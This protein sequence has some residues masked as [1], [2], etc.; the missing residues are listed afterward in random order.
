M[1]PTITTPAMT[2][3]VGVILGTAAY[4][5]PEQAQGQAGRQAQRHL[6]VR[7]RAVRDADRAA[8]LRGRRRLRHAARIVLND[9]PDWARL[10]A[11]VP[12]RIRQVLR[13]CLQ[14]DPKQRIGDTQDVR[15]ALE[16][17]FE[18]AGR[19][20]SAPSTVVNPAF[21]PRRLS[22]ATGLGISAARSSLAIGA[23]AGGD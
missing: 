3:G 11:D 5:S 12:A 22:P 23:T 20:E 18:T 17:A 8:R 10:P 21:V 15:L 9:E 7:L 2:T 6:G 14:K 1:S 13:R 4:M 19:V 16:G